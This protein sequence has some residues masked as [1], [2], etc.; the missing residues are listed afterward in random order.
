MNGRRLIWYLSLL[1]LTSCMQA[2]EAS[3]GPVPSPGTTVL[4]E[5]ATVLPTPSTITPQPTS[6]LPYGL[7]YATAQSSWSED[8]RKTVRAE[9][10]MLKDMGVNTVIQT[11]SSRLIG[12]GDEAD[13]NIFLD[14]AERAEIRVIARL[15]P[16]MDG[17]GTSFDFK[18]IDRFLDVVGD[19]PALLAY[20]GLHEPLERFNSE[21]M[22]TF[23]AGMKQIAPDLP[24][25]HYMGSMALFDSSI[26]F[27]GRRF[28]HGI[29]DI[30]IVWTTP[31]QTRDGEPYFDKKVVISTVRDNRRLIDERSPES[32]LWFLGQSYALQAHRHQLRMPTPDEMEQIFELAI[33]EGADGFLWYPWLHGNYD[34]V[35]SSPGMEAQQKAVRQIYEE[36][37]AAR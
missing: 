34:L 10:A 19:H 36:Y 22:R 2:I 31:A 7:T 25:A 3:Q 14:E 12:T 5:A 24:V 32:E 15:W 4:V 23:Y 33:D 29:C 6:F 1:L 17:D 18:P 35:L 13:W 20:L 8:D 9:L 26:R 16:L 30:C 11:F 28:T 27:P 37:L 21:Q